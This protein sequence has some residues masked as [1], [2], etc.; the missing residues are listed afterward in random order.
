MQRCELEKLL[1]SDHQNTERVRRRWYQ[2]KFPQQEPLP[3]QPKTKP[4]AVDSNPGNPFPP[5][6]PH[7]LRPTGLSRSEGNFD[8]WLHIPKAQEHLEQCL[9]NRV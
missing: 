4:S 9:Q 7:R 3:T 5:T 1:K 2:Q 6:S 8:G